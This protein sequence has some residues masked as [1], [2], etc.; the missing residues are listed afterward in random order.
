MMLVPERGICEMWDSRTSLSEATMEQQSRLGL[1]TAGWAEGQS[2]QG[3]GWAA[4]A[5]VSHRGA[6]SQLLGQEWGHQAGRT[7]AV[8][9]GGSWGP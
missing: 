3:R 5:Q 4:S 9:G 1:E 8:Q 2:S 6:A 7:T